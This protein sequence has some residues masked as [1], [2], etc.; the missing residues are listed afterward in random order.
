VTVLTPS[1]ASSLGQKCQQGFGDE[2]RIFQIG[3]M[4]CL[5]HQLA[6]TATHDRAALTRFDTVLCQGL[7]VHPQVADALAARCA[8]HKQ[9]GF[10]QT[11]GSHETVRSEAAG[12]E[13]PGEAFQGVEAN[14]FGTG[15][16]HAPATQVE[17]L[18]G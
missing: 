9:C 11:V 6:D 5:R 18:Q 3:N 1:R 7:I 17:P 13:L 2:L 8:G 16:R 12:R 10:D 15:I 14:R 4:P